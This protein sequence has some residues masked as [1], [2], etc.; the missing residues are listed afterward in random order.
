MSKPE[1]LFSFGLVSDV[2]YADI[3][4]G[5]SFHGCPRFYKNA[6]IGLRRAVEGW[7]EQNV[8]FSFHLG[9]IVDGFQPKVDAVGSHG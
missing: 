6:L 3:P 7:R 4:D 2:Q 5:V 8:S 9:D 1:V